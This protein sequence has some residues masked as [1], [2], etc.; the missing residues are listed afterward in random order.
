MSDDEVSAKIKL[1]AIALSAISLGELM[2]LAEKTLNNV[3]RLEVRAANPALSE[4][5]MTEFLKLRRL[6]R[7]QLYALDT[8]IEARETFAQIERVATEYGLPNP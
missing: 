5:E 1:V 3:Q 6:A 2:M 4:Q 7:M 8:L